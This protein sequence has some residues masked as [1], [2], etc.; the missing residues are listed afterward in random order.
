LGRK[1]IGIEIDERYYK[2]ACKR[3]E[4]AK[5][6]VGLFSREIERVLLS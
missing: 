3:I 6:N 5:G 2:I 1:F 4:M